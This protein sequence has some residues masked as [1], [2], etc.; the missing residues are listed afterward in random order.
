MQGNANET[1][2]PYVHIAVNCTVLMTPFKVQN[3]FSMKE[4]T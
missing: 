1:D 2:L 3:L 4:M